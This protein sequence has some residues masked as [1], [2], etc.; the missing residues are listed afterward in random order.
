M[1]GNDFICTG[2]CIDHQGVARSEVFHDDPD[3]G[4]FD[5]LAAATG[6][7]VAELRWI[8]MRHQVQ[9]I[10]E[11]LERGEDDSVELRTLRSNIVRRLGRK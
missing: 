10:D 11:Q 8:C 3:R 2:S 7:R 9:I 5:K 1:I 6:K 4:L